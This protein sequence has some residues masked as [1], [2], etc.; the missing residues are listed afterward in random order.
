MRKDPSAV[1]VLARWAEAKRWRVPYEP[2]WRDVLSL[3]MPGRRRLETD[4]L[5]SALDAT[6][7][8]D[9]TAVVGV[10]ECAARIQSGVMPTGVE[11][12]RLEMQGASDEQ[13]QR[14]ADVQRYIF[15]RMAYSNFYSAVTECL[16]DAVGFGNWL[17]RVAY[18][19]VSPG[20]L[21]FEPVPMTQV[22]FAAWH[23]T[24]PDA[25]YVL[26]RYRAGQMR[27]RYPRVELPS[28]VEDHRLYDVVEFCE[29]DGDGVGE[30][31]RHGLLLAHG[32]RS[33]IMWER[34]YQGEGSCP[35]VYGRMSLASGDIYG[36]GPAI[37][38]L[39]SVRTLNA[40]KEKLLRG[41]DLQ[42][43]GLWQA[44]DD[45]VFNPETAVMVPG[46]ILPIAVGSKGLQPLTQRV[47]VDLT[48]LVIA[49]LQHSIRRMLYN[50]TLGPRQGTPP[51]AFE[52]EE[53][54]LDLARQL[55]PAYERI[56]SE[57]CVPLIA[58]LRYLLKRAGM[59]EM[60]VIDGRTVRV[61]P[62]SG[63]A[64]AGAMALGK[65][66]V[67]L[68]QTIGSLFGPQVLMTQVDPTRF[69]QELARL[70]DVPPNILISPQ[71]QARL[72]AQ[73]GA[74]QQQLGNADPALAQAVAAA[75][76][77]MGG[78]QPRSF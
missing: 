17:M 28:D 15:E 8:Y 25:F 41:A 31:Y 37:Q 71:E 1:G 4:S 34:T 50:E 16:I 21:V 73:I 2:Y 70:F 76:G 6:E 60:P 43:G 7:L 52:V 42:L 12:A 78:G 11:W 56:W 44:E 58:R 57:F 13:R 30:R 32:E 63:L 22:W 54:M 68:A 59:I 36:I 47:Q 39:P 72:G 61:E 55:G 64:R 35:F 74:M 48:Q 20:G 77:G 33:S 29:L 5:S 10:P 65:R 14:L 62:F 23:R 27:M 19:P 45:G 40:V 38:A 9:D 69:A 18:D 3:M 26:N 46:A 67:Q 53:R 66:Q 51:T 75:A 24:R 49:D